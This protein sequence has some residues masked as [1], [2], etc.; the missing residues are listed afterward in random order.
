M[1]NKSIFL[2]LTGAALLFGYQIWHADKTLKEY[3]K[4][5]SNRKDEL[6]IAGEMHIVKITDVPGMIAWLG[7]ESTVK[8]DIDSARID[9]ERAYAAVGRVVVPFTRNAV[10]RD[11]ADELHYRRNESLQALKR[12]SADRQG[13]DD[14]ANRFLKANRAYNDQ[15]ATCGL[16]ADG[17]TLGSDGQWQK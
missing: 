12:L 11:C 8:Q 13:T 4:F 17:Y 14:M 2:V 3:V 16:I 10:L 9:E 7:P 6:D 1:V 5:E 15:R